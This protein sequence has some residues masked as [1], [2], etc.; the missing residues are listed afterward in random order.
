[1]PY[2]SASIS[3]LPSQEKREKLSETKSFFNKIGNDP[4]FFPL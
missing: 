2:A 4:F 3:P 1:M